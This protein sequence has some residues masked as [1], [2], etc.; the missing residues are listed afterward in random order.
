MS[1][2]QSKTKTRI[3]GIS[4]IAFA[5]IV[6]VGGAGYAVMRLASNGDREAN[7]SQDATVNN[8]DGKEVTQQSLSQGVNDMNE[9]VKES[10]EAHEQAKK[11]VEDPT[12]RVK[13]SE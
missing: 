9:S 11:A 6:I 3:I 12:K 13:V 8:E 1:S 4:V 5:I 10:Q 7:T 2:A